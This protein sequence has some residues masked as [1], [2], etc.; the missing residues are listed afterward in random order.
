MRTLSAIALVFSITA[1]LPAIAYTHE[2][3]VACT[4][5]AMRLC[6]QFLPNKGRVI[7][8]LV[9]NERQLGP[10]CKMAF[11]R[12]RAVVASRERPAGVQAAKF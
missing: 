11:A 9:H 8:C 10:A 6:R 3:V 7:L 1:P 2:D 12:V 4:P 5:D